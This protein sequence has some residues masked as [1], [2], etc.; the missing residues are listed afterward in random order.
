LAGN[1]FVADGPNLWRLRPPVGDSDGD[2]VANEIDALP[3]NP[4]EDT[5]TD[6]DGIGNNA[7][8]DDDGDGLSDSQEVTLGTDPLN[9]DSDGDGLNDGDEI[10]NATD[11]M[12]PDSDGPPLVSGGGELRRAGIPAHPRRF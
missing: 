10:A 11:P 1:L 7:D 8:P 12:N 2:G 6:A 3:F 5:D 9:P 4:T